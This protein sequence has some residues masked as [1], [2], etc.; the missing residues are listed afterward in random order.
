MLVTYQTKGSAVV[1]DWID[2]AK[3]RL[4]KPKVVH[5]RRNSVQEKITLLF[6]PIAD[7]RADGKN[8]SEVRDAVFPNGEVPV[9]T[10]RTSFS[11]EASKRGLIAG[12]NVAPSRTV[13]K[14][15]ASCRDE[16]GKR[17]PVVTLAEAKASAASEGP[18]TN[19]QNP[20]HGAEDASRQVGFSNLTSRWTDSDDD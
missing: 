5:R 14:S 10:V 18:P 2:S 7:A 12:K 6:E 4:A 17:K 13:S 1:D 19:R 20:P 3:A 8:W 11:R 16:R 15:D 9:D